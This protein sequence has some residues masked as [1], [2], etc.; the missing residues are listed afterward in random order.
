MAEHKHGEMDI[1]E[2][3]QM[4]DKFVHFWFYL[5]LGAAAVLILLAL[6]NA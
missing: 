6:T 5:F 2:H 4:F 1:E 3:K